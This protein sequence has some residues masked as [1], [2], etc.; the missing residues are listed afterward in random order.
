MNWVTTVSAQRKA[1]SCKK[2]DELKVDGIEIAP[3]FDDKADLVLVRTM[4][5]FVKNS[6]VV[7]LPQDSRRDRQGV[8]R[9]H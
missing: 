6:T 2:L 4:T 8:G 3:S 9:K 7:A 1:G 5:T